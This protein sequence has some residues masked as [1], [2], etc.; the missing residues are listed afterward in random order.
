MRVLLIEDD[1]NLSTFYSRALRRAGHDVT[2]QNRGDEGLLVVQKLK[3]DA[4]VL[5]WFLPGL[6]GI[7][8][9]KEMRGIGM[10][11]PVLM[12]SGSGDLGREE[13]LAAGA[14]GFLGKPCGL[15]ELADG[16]SALGTRT[17]I[18]DLTSHFA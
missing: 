17:K 6:D 12:L 3:F 10:E 8:L 7:S 9:L 5:D 11:T 14:D 13:A 4:I 18:R 2:V 1:P 16:V 15:E